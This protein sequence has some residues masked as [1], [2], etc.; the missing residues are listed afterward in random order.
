MEH[1]GTVAG[2]WL[3]RFLRFRAVRQPGTLS[4]VAFGTEL[5]TALR[6]APSA[7][8]LKSL[9]TFSLGD[10]AQGM[11]RALADLYALERDALGESAREVNAAAAAGGVWRGPTSNF[12]PT[13]RGRR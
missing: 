3:G 6:G 1:G 9:G 5:P 10:G 13:T 12:R 7:T 8:V 11:L 2:G 4:A